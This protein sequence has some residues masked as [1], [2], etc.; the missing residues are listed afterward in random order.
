MK[1]GKVYLT[2]NPFFIPKLE[3]GKSLSI[4][5]SG[6]NSLQV[7]NNKNITLSEFAKNPYQEL[8][9]I[10]NLIFIGNSRIIN[11]ANRIDPV[12]EVIHNN[13][14]ELNKIIID[15]NLFISEPWR[16]IFAFITVNCNFSG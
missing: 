8:K 15:N 1:K 2:S 7:D 9:G 3:D 4:I 6:F 5:A 11:P 13:T 16:I 14:P 10:D 12:F